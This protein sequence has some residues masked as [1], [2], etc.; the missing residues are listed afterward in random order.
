[1]CQQL[2]RKQYVS[3]PA[4]F[5]ELLV[6]AHL[7]VTL[8]AHMAGPVAATGETVLPRRSSSTKRSRKEQEEGGDCIAADLSRNRD[9]NCEKRAALHF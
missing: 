4:G 8:L 5:S 1:M 7:N 2:H 6:S 9:V 3:Y